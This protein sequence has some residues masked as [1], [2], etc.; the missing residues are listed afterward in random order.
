M[1]AHVAGKFGKGEVGE[2]SRSRSEL[3]RSS[4][5]VVPHDLCAG[6]PKNPNQIGGQRRRFSTPFS[7]VPRGDSVARELHKRYMALGEHWGMVSS[8]RPGADF[9]VSLPPFKRRYRN[10]N[11]NF[12][13]CLRRLS[14]STSFKLGSWVPRERVIAVGSLIGSK[15]RCQASFKRAIGVLPVS[16]ER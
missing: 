3:C 13:G 5:E 2:P 16:S 15:C 12:Y 4:V 10:W 9:P 11:Q 7:D 14:A 8:V 6:Q 1:K